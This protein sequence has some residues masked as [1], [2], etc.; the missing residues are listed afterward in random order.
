M[1]MN[2]SKFVKALIGLVLIFIW[3]AGCG[4]FPVEQPTT[5][6]TPSPHANHGDNPTAGAIQRSTRQAQATLNGQATATRQAALASETARARTNATATL[7]ARATRQSVIAARSAWPRRISESFKDNALGWP[8]G[9]TTDTSPV[10][11]SN[12]SNGSY[13]WSV[14]V[15]HGNSYINLIPENGPRLTDFY[16]SVAV[17]FVAGEQGDQTSYGLVF[18]NVKKDYGFFGISKS[19]DFRILE[20]HHTD[21]YSLD[22]ES[23][24]A[25]DTR[26]GQVNRIAVAAVGP[27]FVFF[28]NNKVVGQMTADIDPGQIGLGVDALNSADEAKVTFSGFEVSAP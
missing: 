1:D 21:I 4:S 12:I 27:D 13:Q 16:A 9:V 18:R 22:Q 6:W 8:L 10:V 19:G 15:P 7:V 17:Q 25:I 20:V 5:A 14:V 3:V 11:S 24:Q 28:I 2:I 26:P 23:S